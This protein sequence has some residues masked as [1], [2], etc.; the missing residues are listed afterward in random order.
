VFAH[1]SAQTHTHTLTLTFFKDVLAFWS[2]PLK[3]VRTHSHRSYYSLSRTAHLRSVRLPILSGR[4][5]R[6]DWCVCACMCTCVLVGIYAHCIESRSLFVTLSLAISFCLFLLSS[7]YLNHSHTNTHTHAHVHTI[8]GRYP[9]TV[10]VLEMLSV[11]IHNH[12]IW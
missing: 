11:I 4:M 10:G 9:V 5:W 8:Q 2:Y 3:H 1:R 6:V 12:E 7:L